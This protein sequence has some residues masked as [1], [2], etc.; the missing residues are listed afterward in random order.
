MSLNV[1]R[2]L[3]LKQHQCYKQNKTKKS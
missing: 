1:M 3:T 2:A